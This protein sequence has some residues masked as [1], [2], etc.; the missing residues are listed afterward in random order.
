VCVFVVLGF[1]TQGFILARADA[2]P[3]EPL[4]HQHVADLSYWNTTSP[5]IV[6]HACILS[7][8]ET[9]V[10]R[11]HILGLAWAMQDHVS[12]KP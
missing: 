9:K 4:L 11:L 5:G 8:W 3:F 1:W 12:K 6:M 7:T 2:L 10:G